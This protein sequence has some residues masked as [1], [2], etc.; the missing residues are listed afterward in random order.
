M[1]LKSLEQGAKALEG[2]DHGAKWPLGHDVVVF[3]HVAASAGCAIRAAKS[4]HACCVPT[5][6]WLRLPPSLS[7]IEAWRAKLACQ[8]A[9]V[10]LATKAMTFK[11]TPDEQQSS[12]P[13]VIADEFTTQLDRLRARALCESLSRYVRHMGVRLLCANVHR[14]V[15]AWLRPCWIL[16]TEHGEL[17]FSDSTLAENGIWA[18]IMGGIWVGTL[19]ILGGIWADTFGWY[20]NILVGIWGSSLV[21]NGRHLGAEFSCRPALFVIIIWPPCPSRGWG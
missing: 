4:L 1:T 15:V 2:G 8:L 13:M 19:R 6:C 20:L 11:G 21:V 14:D 12:L 3:S 7:R 5:D 17:A 10:C 16:D 18:D 9:A